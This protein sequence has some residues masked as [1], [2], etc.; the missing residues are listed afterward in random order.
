MNAKDHPA[1]DGGV[2]NAVRRAFSSPGDCFSVYFDGKA[3][4]VCASEAAAPK[5][6]DL[7]C[8]AQ[9]WDVDTVQLR[10]PGAYSE[11]RKS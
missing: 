1:Y 7:V 11:W 9:R 8:I 5:D 10:F 4:F 2:N 3:I 6:A